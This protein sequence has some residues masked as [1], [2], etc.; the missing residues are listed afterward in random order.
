M[1]TPASSAVPYR[2][3]RHTGESV[4]WDGHGRDAVAKREIERKQG[5]AEPRGIALLVDMREAAGAF[6]GRENRDPAQRRAPHRLERPYAETHKPAAGFL[7]KRVP[8]PPRD[9]V[10]AAAEW[11]T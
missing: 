5:V 2:D 10:Y 4:L 1:P 6:L 3:T 8:P 9:E 7:A 11:W